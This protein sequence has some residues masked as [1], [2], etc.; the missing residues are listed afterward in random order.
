MKQFFKARGRWA[1][2]FI[3]FLCSLVAGCSKKGN[4]IQTPPPI[5][6][7][8]VTM[9]ALPSAS[10]TY[11]QEVTVSYNAINVVGTGTGSMTFRP[12]KDTLVK[13]TFTGINGETVTGGILIKVSAP[14][15]QT[16]LLTNSPWKIESKMYLASDGTWQY[17]TLNAC[18]LPD[19]HDFHLDFK[20]YSDHNCDPTFPGS[21]SKYLLSGG[22]LNWGGP[23]YVVKEL[24]TTNLV[25]YQDVPPI[26][27]GNPPLPVTWRYKH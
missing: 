10:V 3:I 25:L 5:P 12:Y 27:P 1:A 6:K 26:I 8:S 7:P 22:Q 18:E 20:V 13:K 15:A 17:F 11:G 4:D 19:K 24:T 9:T 2:A 21:Y 16:L 14:D 23:V